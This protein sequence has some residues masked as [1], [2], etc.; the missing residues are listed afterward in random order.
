MVAGLLV[1]PEVRPQVIFTVLLV[2]IGIL[3]I[4]GPEFIYLR[5][6]F[7]TRMNTVFKFYYQAWI[8]LALAAACS[9]ARIFSSTKG[10]GGGIAALAVI[11]V[12]V[13]GL[14]YPALGLY[15][16]TDKFQPANGLTLDGTT[17]SAYLNQDDRAAVAWLE[18]S[19]LGV[20]VEAVGGS[21]SGAAR[22]STHSGQPAV[23]GWTGHEGQWRGDYEEVNIRR[24]A[25]EEIYS[26]GNW[27]QTAALLDRYGVTYLYLGS[28]EHSTYT[29][30]EQKFRRNMPVLFEQGGVVIFGYTPAGASP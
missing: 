22:I 29:V 8:L 17:H 16:K 27:D 15:T 10:L 20:L 3:L 19:D 5:D 26:S 21:Y 14:T 7:G 9:T 12:L 6:F 1:R 4:L 24:D 25:I 11:G 23:L 2:A 18:A 30:N 13:A 28:L